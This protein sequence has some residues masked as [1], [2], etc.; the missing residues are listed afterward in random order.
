[1]SN[2]RYELMNTTNHTLIDRYT[3]TVR[4]KHVRFANLIDLYNCDLFFA[5]M[6]LLSLLSSFIE[7]TALSH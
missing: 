6:F 7:G 3:Y 2:Y 1:M 5:L 4:I